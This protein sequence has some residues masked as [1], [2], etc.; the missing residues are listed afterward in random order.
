MNNAAIQVEKTFGF[1]KQLQNI[2]I[3]LP[4]KATLWLSNNIGVLILQ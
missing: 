3:Y 1:E 2:Y 4:S